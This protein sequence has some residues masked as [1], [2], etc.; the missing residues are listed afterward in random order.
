MAKKNNDRTPVVVENPLSS[1]LQSQLEDSANGI[2]K[3][4]ASSFLSSQ[5]SVM[6]YD[7]RQANTMQ[8]TLIFTMAITWLLHFKMEMVQPLVTQIISGFLNLCCS[9][10][11]QV[12]VLGR[13]LERPFKSPANV[14]QKAVELTDGRE[15]EG[16]EEASESEAISD[17]DFSEESSIQDSVSDKESDGAGS[18]QP[19]AGQSEDDTEANGHEDEVDSKSKE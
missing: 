2:V 6:E 3:N 17:Q 11:F 5:I 16:E 13:N 19:N 10:L 7:L 18:G 12:Y 4:L 9:P 1:V 14:T 8:G 15:D